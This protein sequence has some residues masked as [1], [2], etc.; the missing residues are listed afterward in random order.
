MCEAQ[1]FVTGGFRF[2]ALSGFAS[3]F[4]S[5]QKGPSHGQA[6]SVRFLLWAGRIDMKNISKIW[7]PQKAIG[8]GKAE[9]NL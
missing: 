9:L 3:L 8:R 6:A 1:P 4:A 7:V 2:L 5:Y